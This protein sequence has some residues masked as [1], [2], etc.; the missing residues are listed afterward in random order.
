MQLAATKALAQLAATSP[1]LAQQ[2]CR[3]PGLMPALSALLMTHSTP[4]AVR[5]SISACLTNMCRWARPRAA[6]ARAVEH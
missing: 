3:Q 6:G 1:E 2:L 5:A 4:A